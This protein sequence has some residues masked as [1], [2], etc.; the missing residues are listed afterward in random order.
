MITTLNK[1]AIDGMYI[2]IIKIKYD[3]PA[4]NIVLDKWKAEALKI[5][6]KTRKSTVT[7]FMQHRIGIPSQSN[8][9]KKEIKRYPN[10]K[11]E[12]CHYLQMAWY[13]I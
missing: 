11:K 12:N 1:E 13:Y 9:V 7:I 3:K 10:K 2:N 4:T 5:R 8:I 6:K